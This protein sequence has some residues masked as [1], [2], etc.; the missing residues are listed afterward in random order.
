MN[1]F[2]CIWNAL[3]KDDEPDKGSPLYTN[4]DFCRWCFGDGYRCLSSYGKK[5]MWNDLHPEL[6]VFNATDE[7]YQ[8]DQLMYEYYLKYLQT[9][10]F[11]NDSTNEK[12][13][14]MP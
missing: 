5:Q 14:S 12:P 10:D 9:K 8:K 1:I 3:F 13:N 2:R 7:I 6:F 11:K 4:C